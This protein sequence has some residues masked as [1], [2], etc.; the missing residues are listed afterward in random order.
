[1]LPTIAAIKDIIVVNFVAHNLPF[2]VDSFDS[3]IDRKHFTFDC[4]EAAIAS[5]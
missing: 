3:N 5:L 1:M 4:K 2:V